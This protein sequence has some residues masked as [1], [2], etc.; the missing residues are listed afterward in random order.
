M[1]SERRQ[2]ARILTV[3]V[4]DLEYAVINDLAQAAGVSLAE[5]ARAILFDRQPATPVVPRSP[6]HDHCTPHHR[7]VV[8]RYRDERARQELELE[9]ITGGYP[10]D[11]EHW[12]Q[13]GG[14]L[15]TF[16]TWLRSQQ[17]S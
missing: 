13:N 8:D 16:Q 14:Q 1:G 11:L 9:A 12:R 7:D 6:D 10:G 15:T 4:D 5:M 2:R 17:A 3:R